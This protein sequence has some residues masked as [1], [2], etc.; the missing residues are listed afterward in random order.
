MNAKV[1]HAIERRVAAS[2]IADL[3]KAGY[4]VSVND[5]EEI[6]LR[7]STNPAAILEAMFSTDE[8]YLLANGPSLPSGWVRFVYG[9]DGPDV[10]NDYST[11]LTT[12]L[13]GTVR[14]CDCIADMLDDYSNTPFDPAVLI[15]PT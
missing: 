8:D 6:T 10:I 3:L 4:T 2:T 11:N 14:L 7:D 15:I 5:G 1:T 13:A 9:N 12:A